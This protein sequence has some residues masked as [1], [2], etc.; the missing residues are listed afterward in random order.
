MKAGFNPDALQLALYKLLKA[1]AGAEIVRGKL[2]CP[3]IAL[4]LSVG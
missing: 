1:P 2:S 4:A 3:K